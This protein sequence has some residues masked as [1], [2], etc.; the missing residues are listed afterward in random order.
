MARPMRMSGDQ[1]FA[2]PKPPPKSPVK[3]GERVELSLREIESLILRRENYSYGVPKWMGF[4][5]FF[6]E[7]DVKVEVYDSISTVSKYIFLSRTQKKKGHRRR[8]V[9]CKIRF[10][11]HEPNKARSLD[12]DIII[13][14]SH[15]GVV[16]TEQGIREVALFFKSR[17]CEVPKTRHLTTGG[18]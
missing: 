12:V 7:R 1:N 8:I 13:G 17:G 10:S 2:P 5:R 16:T 11:N 14:L 3:K 6:A 15:R 9:T 4:C 18:I